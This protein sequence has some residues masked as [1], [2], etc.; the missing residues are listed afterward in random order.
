MQDGTNIKHN[1]RPEPGE[2]VVLALHGGAYIK[3]SAHPS[4]LA[5]VIGR[6]LIKHADRVQRVFAPEYRLSSTQPNE[7]A[8]PF[9]T[10]LLDALTAYVFL[11]NEI[12]FDPSDIIIE[13]DSAGG[14]LAYALTRYLVEYKGTPEL[15][16]PPGALI[17]VCPWADVSY[18]HNQLDN[19][20]A[21]NNITS[22]ILGDPNTNFN[23]AIK[24]FTGPHGLDAAKNNPYISPASLDGS[25]VVNFK[26]FPR[27]FIVAGGAEVILD[28]IKTLRDRMIKDLGE[29]NG[30]SDGDGKV[31][32]HEAADGIHDYLAFSWHEPEFTDTYKAIAE[33]I[34]LA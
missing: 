9:P 10:A 15:P 21:L 28:Q 30:V 16:A 3:L 32:Y 8:H 7:E 24:A 13:G 5:G 14:N 22:D 19:G 4:D 1:S 29:G 26:G 20:S 6:S 18:S 11:V 33:W 17:L 23:Y 34:S 2:K 27:T 12:G 25:L 31:R